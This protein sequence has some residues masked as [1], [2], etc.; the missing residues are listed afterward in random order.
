MEIIGIL[1]LLFIGIII[2][3]FLILGLK[4]GIFLITL[5]LKI[6]FTIIAAMLAVFLLPA[7]ILPVLLSIIVLFLP[8]FLIGLGI[9]LL[10]NYA[11]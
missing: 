6:I 8:F 3:K 4:M 10:I 2:F 1:I 11:A 9:I 7:V 5:P